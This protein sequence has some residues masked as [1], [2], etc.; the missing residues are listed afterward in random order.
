[1]ALQSWQL[2]TTMMVYL[3]ENWTVGVRLTWRVSGF[4]GI[5]LRCAGRSCRGQYW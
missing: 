2:A 4:K 3:T 5:A 1:M